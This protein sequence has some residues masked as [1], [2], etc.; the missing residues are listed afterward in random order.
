MF[1]WMVTG[2]RQA[3]RIRGLYL[4]AILRQDI[5]FFD[6][7][8]STGDVIGRM[9]G[10]TILIQEAMS[11]KVGNFIQVM[12]SFVGGFAIA[13]I[14]GWLLTLVLCSCIPA[15]VIAGGFMSLLLLKTSSRGQDA[16]AEA[17]NVVEQTI[18]GIRTVCILDLLCH[19][20]G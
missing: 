7:E 13:F 10:D 11:V 9:S 6:M 5:A 12:S 18:G 8:T 2:E 15:L 20:L 16:Y 19:F 3:A 1:C 17:G 14:K 4:Q